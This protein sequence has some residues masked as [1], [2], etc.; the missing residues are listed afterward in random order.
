MCGVSGS[1]R[2]LFFAGC[3]A[4]V[5]AFAGPCETAFTGVMKNADYFDVLLNGALFQNSE[6]TPGPRA[7][8]FA[9]Q[10]GEI[11]GG[12]DKVWISR[13]PLDLDEVK[14]EIWKRGGQGLGITVCT[15]KDNGDPVELRKLEIENKDAASDKPFH[16]TLEGVKNRRVWVH[17]KNKN[18]VEPFSYGIRL[19]RPNQG[20][21]RSVKSDDDLPEV[22]GFADLHVH[23]SA[24]MAFGGGFVW[25]D[26]NGKMKDCTGENHGFA[27]KDDTWAGLIEK[28]VPGTDKKQVHSHARRAGKDWPNAWDLADHQQVSENHLYQAWKGGLRLMISVAENHQG[29]CLAMKVLHGDVAKL[30]CDDM[31]SVKLQLRALHDFA[32]EHKWYRIARDPWEARRIIAD[33]DLA[34]ILGVEVSNLFPKSQGDWEQQLDELYDLGARQFEIA[35]ESDSDFAGSAQQQGGLYAALNLLKQA[36]KWNWADLFKRTD[37]DGPNAKNTVGLKDDGKDLVAEMMKRKMLISIDHLSRKARDQV[38]DLVEK[39]DCYPIIATHTQFDTILDA[40]TKGHTQEYML[41][42]G[43]VADIIKTGGVLGLRTAGDALEQVD[44]C[45]KL[46]CKGSS[47]SV[48]QNVCK[49]AQI[50]V[51]MALGSDISGGPFEM[52]SPR[53]PSDERKT[54]SGKTAHCPGGGKNAW[55]EKDYP[56]GVDTPEEREAGTGFD[57]QGLSHIGFEPDLLKDLEKLGAPVDEVRLDSSAESLLRSWERAWDSQRKCLSKAQY[58]E[59]MMKRDGPAVK[60]LKTK[61]HVDDAKPS[62]K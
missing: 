35:H 26:F 18:L 59:W 41:T 30:P 47:E 58:K 5:P 29:L 49:G 17:L 39:K 27:H 61:L 16:W 40:E 51:A 23:Q 43:T 15:Q 3:L 9:Y 36:F 48:A 24:N 44:G 62:Y 11:L 42:D 22:R 53:F 45:V 1:I 6:A 21:L 20:E 13:L 60:T 25:G 52:T 37:L 50:G 33:G 7:L 8:S 2:A 12:L 31:D 57:V 34:V 14:L 4:A 54:R 10:K 32:K 55:K 28:L 46:R 56:P 38:I 19:K